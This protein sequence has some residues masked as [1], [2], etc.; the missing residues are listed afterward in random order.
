MGG[1]TTGPVDGWE[2]FS[3]NAISRHGAVLIMVWRKE[4]DER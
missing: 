1:S 3:A 4:R 2:L